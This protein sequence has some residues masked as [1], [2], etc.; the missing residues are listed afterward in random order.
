MDI[1][2]LPTAM[3]WFCL[4]SSEPTSVLM[5]HVYAMPSRIYTITDLLPPYFNG[6]FGRLFVV[7][8]SPSKMLRYL[9][10]NLSERHPFDRRVY[11]VTVFV[12]PL[13]NDLCERLLRV[14]LKPSRLFIALLRPFYLIRPTAACSCGTPK[15]KALLLLDAWPVGRLF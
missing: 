12:S 14:C 2:S 15:S 13:F 3:V 11:D 10:R 9:L 1:S 5:T 7:P 8:Y 4:S 6:I